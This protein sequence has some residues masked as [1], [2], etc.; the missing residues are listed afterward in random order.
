MYWSLEHVKKIQQE[1]RG[2]TSIPDR[3]FG[4]FRKQYAQGIFQ[5]SSELVVI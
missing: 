2:Y 4:P 1:P 3:N 5:N